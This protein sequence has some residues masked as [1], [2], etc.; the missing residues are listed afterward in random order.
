MHG[1][2][3]HIQ[4]ALILILLMLLI[5]GCGAKPKTGKAPIINAFT[6]PEAVYSRTTTNR[7]EVQATDP[8]GNYLT[9]KWQAT[10]GSGSPAGPTGSYYD[11]QAPC[12]VTASTITV[13]VS[14]GGQSVSANKNISVS[15]DPAEFDLDI[16]VP[17]A[18]AAG[19]E[20]PLASTV[21]SKVGCSLSSLSYNWSVS[22]GTILS[23]TPSVYFPG[24]A[25]WRPPITEGAATVSVTVNG[26]SGIQLEKSAN[27]TV[28]SPDVKF[29]EARLDGQMFKGTV[30]NMGT[31]RV[32]WLYFRVSPT[33]AFGYGVDIPPG[34]SDIVA[35]TLENPDWTP[36]CNCVAIYIGGVEYTNGLKWTRRLEKTTDTSATEVWNEVMNWTGAV[37]YNKGWTTAEPW[38]CK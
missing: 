1:Q 4:L 18:A 17:N 34:G 8:E 9:Y 15:R 6:G 37:Y 2:G 16:D 32:D 5:A 14:D 20:T 23:T 3:S 35:F 10:N 29:T 12:D 28:I 27:V 26:P 25:Q 19:H 38:A 13:T 7:Y 11:W 21:S 31:R 36:S 33:K 30:K 24:Y 22:A